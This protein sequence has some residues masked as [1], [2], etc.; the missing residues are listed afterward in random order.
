MHD[1]EN[2]QNYKSNQSDDNVIS[3]VKFLD[4]TL[5]ILM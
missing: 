3:F 2:M 5:R 4:I 1:Y